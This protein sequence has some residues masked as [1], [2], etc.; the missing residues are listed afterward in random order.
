M[1]TVEWTRPG[2]NVL[3]VAAVARIA[4]STTRTMEQRGTGDGGN[5]KEIK[6]FEVEVEVEDA[7]VV[8]R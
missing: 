4:V 6:D 7:A 1:G 8:E 3:D 2:G 5:M